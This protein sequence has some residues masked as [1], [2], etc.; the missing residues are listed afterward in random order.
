MLSYVPPPPEETVD[1]SRVSKWQPRGSNIELWQQQV[2][3]CFLKSGHAQQALPVLIF[4]L[5]NP[6]QQITYLCYQI[7]SV[8]ICI[9]VSCIKVNLLWPIEK[10]NCWIFRWIYTPSCLAPRGNLFIQNPRDF[11][12]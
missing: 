12:K 6:L 10:E 1:S 8:G 7:V 11:L 2:V 3:Y 4:I 9:C 5:H